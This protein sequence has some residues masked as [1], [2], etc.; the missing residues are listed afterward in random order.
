M[1]VAGE[2]IPSVPSPGGRP[3]AALKEQDF[4]DFFENGAIGLHLVGHD[5]T[6]LRANKA[7]LDM[8]GY[9]ADQYVGRNIAD[10]HADAPTISDIL[11]RLTAGEK[12]D[13]Y[14]ARLRTR[15]GSIR[16]VL[17]TS[18]VRFADGQFVNTRC[19]T[20]DV[21]D[22]KK[23]QDML[24]E[25]EAH[26]SQLLDAL[27]A[28][29]YTTD[30]RG[31]ITY[32]NKAAVEFSG[33]EPKLGEDQWCVTW[34]LYSPDGTPQPHDQS[35]I[36]IA[37]RG[38]RPVRDVEAIAERPDGS[39]VPF[40]PFPTP[41]RGSNGELTGA[42]N[43]LVDISERKKAEAQ[44]SLLVRELHHRVKNTLATVQAV[45]GTTMRHS[46]TMEEF[47]HAFI[48]RV[49]ALSKTHSLLTEDNSQLVSFLTL[50]N[51]ELQPFDND[52]S[53]IALEGNDVMLPAHLAVPIGMAIH[54]LTTNAVK[55]GALSI[56]GGALSVKW[57]SAGNYLLFSWQEDNVPDVQAPK[58]TGFGSQ[59]LLKVLPQQIEAQTTLDYEPTGLRASFSV[60]LHH[61]HG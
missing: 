49:A 24:A 55:H 35:P 30:A 21:T 32:Y 46:A 33:R 18:S 36:A 12:L 31:I 2:V 60:P 59:L 57:T 11:R 26:F 52:G 25:R 13:K 20:I 37:L 51:N 29:I 39:R 28:A 44:Q 38:D 58:H 6:I 34:R 3:D 14:P 4:E 40:T 50:L 5:G 17:I 56:S 9:T 1:S 23:A 16:D 42:V 47:Q 15:D 48:G 8:M 43:M 7:E 61:G 53:R 45:M 54:E 27:P 41:L 22:A 19:F 10:F